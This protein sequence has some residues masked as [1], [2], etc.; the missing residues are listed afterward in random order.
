MS[1][2]HDAAD[3]YLSIR[4][5][6]GFKLARGEGLLLSFVDF[7]DAQGATRVTSELAL[8]WATLP[9][10]ASPSWWNSRLCVVRCFARHLSAAD[11]STEVPPLD[12]LPR[13]PARTLRAT[14]YLYS[15]A[16]IAAL[17]DAAESKRFPLT[18]ATCRTLI[19]LL[20]V[21]GM[22]VGEALR[23]E[24]ADLDWARGVLIVRQSKFDRSREVPLHPSTLDA[25][26]A[27]VDV[28]D[29]R[30][31]RPRSVSFF[32]SWTG[33]ALSYRTVNGHFADLVD[34]AGLEPKSPRCRPRMHDFRHRFASETLQ[35][36]YRAGID[37]QSR[38]PLLSTF[39]GHVDPI[40]TYWYLSAKP[41]LMASAAER[42]ER[43]LGVLP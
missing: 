43:F 20:A 29:Q 2:L 42:L 31:P 40:S 34:K 23:L 33:T 37:V 4:R 24:D 26:G 17:M 14:P 1:A 19:G 22:R 5:A 10:G 18:A 7:A 6:V 21:T 13:V 30:F 35:D 32:V 39:L 16:E 38:L 36:W 3:E 41:E 8:R 28:R 15:D 9:A 11:P 27:Y 25:L 12:L